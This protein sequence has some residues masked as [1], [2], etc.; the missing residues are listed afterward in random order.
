MDNAFTEGKIKKEDLPRLS[1]ASDVGEKEKDETHRGVKLEVVKTIITET[2]PT[3]KE[4][5][6][7]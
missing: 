1:F 4:K 2:P 5:P 3:Y 6:I 7:I